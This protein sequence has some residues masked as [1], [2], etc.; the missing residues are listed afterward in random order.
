MT[1]GGE[2]MRRSARVLGYLAAGLV[3]LGGAGAARA[4]GGSEVMLPSAPEPAAT[5]AP[6]SE[7]S[8]EEESFTPAAGAA[9]GAAAS[10]VQVNGYIDI[11]YA[12]A[13]GDGTSY[14]PGD[15]RLPADYGVDTFAPA[16]NSR[17]DVAS[18]DAGGRFVNG[19]LPYSVGIG[20]KPSL[21]LNVVDADLKYAP[22]GA[23]ILVFSRVLLLPRFSDAGAATRVLVEQAF[24]R[25]TPLKFAELAIS[26]GKFDSV[27]GVEYLDNPSTIR[28][29]I[30]PS[31]IAR[32]TTG[33]SLGAKLFFRQQIAP[34]WSAI[35]LNAAATNSGNMVESLQVPDKSLTGQAVVSGRLGYEL[36]LEL[37]QVKLGGSG[38][39]GPR[40][41]QRDPA[42][43]Q[44]MLG[45]DVRVVIAGATVS[46]EYVKVDEDR[47]SAEGK[48]TG[49]GMFPIASGFH[50]RGYYAQAAYTL[51]LGNGILRKVT[52]YARYERRHAWFEGFIPLT[53][54]RVTAGL[55]VD[56]WE[57][58]IVKGEVLINREIEGAPTVDNNVYTSSLVWSW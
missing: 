22:A 1:M 44:K 47:G 21:L 37:L 45:G 43:K 56:L 15:S 46:G 51:S 10:P 55:R 30:T 41:D 42:A 14:P 27:F 23:P 34:I 13:Q 2:Q 39:Y 32:Y 17:G 24:G 5:E 19:F 26:I 49:L 54:E 3:V 50:A 11:G 6:P 57:T 52:P 53:V 36:N 9:T 28:L 16:V 29:G 4:Q 31:L 35:S 40:N 58:L 33:T 7:A 8:A 48:I 12:K 18:T 25:I 20:S 38:L